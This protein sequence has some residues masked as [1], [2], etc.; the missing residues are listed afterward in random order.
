MKLKTMPARNCKRCGKLLS[1]YNKEEECFHH[2][3]DDLTKSP[4]TMC[5]SPTNPGKHVAIMDYYG[6]P[7]Q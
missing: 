2:Y 3:T 4:V 6:E 5:T 1:M 7:D